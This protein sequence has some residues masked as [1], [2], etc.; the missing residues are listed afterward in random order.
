MQGGGEQG[1]LPPNYLDKQ[2]SLRPGVLFDTTPFGK[3][4]G[5][6]ET[7]VQKSYKVVRC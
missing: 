6:V 2:W 5:D 4:F 1:P 3:K 7:D